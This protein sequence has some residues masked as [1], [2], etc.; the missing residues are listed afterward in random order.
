MNF[1]EENRSM[2]DLFALEAFYPQAPE[3]NAAAWQ[4][5]LQA[6]LGTV[7]IVSANPSLILLALRAKLGL[8]RCSGHARAM[9]LHRCHHRAVCTRFIHCRARHRVSRRD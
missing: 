8:A 4:Q 1:N 3:L 7:D 6:Q 9:P 5:H 2:P